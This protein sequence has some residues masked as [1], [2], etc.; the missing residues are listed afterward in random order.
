M[1]SR[2]EARN[3]DEQD[4]DDIA[5]ISGSESET[6]SSDSE[7][8]EG[9]DSRLPRLYFGVVGEAD[10]RGAGGGL[11]KCFS[12]YRTLLGRFSHSHSSRYPELLGYIFCVRLDTVGT[13]MIIIQK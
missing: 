7:D 13:G 2:K 3:D 12:I 1:I 8:S 9:L 10:A 4:D 5:S 11:G 6:E